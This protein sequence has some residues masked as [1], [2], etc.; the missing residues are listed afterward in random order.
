M[1]PKVKLVNISD[2][3]ENAW[4]F[5]RPT[6]DHSDLD[7]NKIGS[8]DIGLNSLCSLT[9]EITSSVAFRD[10]LLSIRPIYCWARSSRGVPL[11]KQTISAEFGLEGLSN[12]SNV[13]YNINKGV[14]QDE[15]RE[16]LPLS[17]STSYTV[18]MDFRTCVG[19]IK[20]MLK[21]DKDMFDIYGRQFILETDH[22]PGFDK[23]KV[24]DFLGIYLPTN[25]DRELN[26]LSHM[27][28]QIAG[29]YLMKSA[30]SAQFIRS[31]QAKVKNG[32]WD[33]IY[34]KGYMSL[35]TMIQADRFFMYFYMDSAAY[36]KMMQ[37]R[38]HWFADWSNDMWG[39]IIGDYTR[40]MSTD[41]FWDFI[42]AGNGK[43]DPYAE[44]IMNRVK[45]E[46]TN[47]PCPIMLEQPDLIGK[48]FDTFGYNQI[49]GRYNDL[50][51]E[52]YIKDN[53]DNK[54]RRMYAERNK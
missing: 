30:L 18:M 52:G 46:D 2:S 44:E 28:S 10:W 43:I 48:R 53:P 54:Y 38:S 33:Y 24:K 6:F 51:A 29:K 22:I 41:E 50:A 31:S 32:L 3:R 36:R 21:I 8:M 25:K 45:G 35:S 14:D 26:P 20:T 9:F 4:V 47:L 16:G 13:I 11:D 37:M 39:N 19:M 27:G 17:M 34:N 23:S 5:S 7:M 12:L 1:N 40:G 42:P 49:I 15:A